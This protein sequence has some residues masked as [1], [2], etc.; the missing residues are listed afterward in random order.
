MTEGLKYDTGKPPIDLVDSETILAIATV[1][2]YGAIKYEPHN[3]RKGIAWSRL[4][5]GVQRHLLAFWAGEEI[6]P[7]SGLPHLAHA[8]CGLMFLQ[9]HS[10][11]RADLDD[12]WKGG[13]PNAT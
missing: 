8:G 1:L 4:Y 10:N 9:W 2:A 7:E 5:A 3:W 12:R 13:Q 6:D 11:H